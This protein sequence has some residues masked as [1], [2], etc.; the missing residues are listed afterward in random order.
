M[1]TRIDTQPSEQTEK[2]TSN[3]KTSSKDAEKL[4]TRPDMRSK[5][6]E[7]R[8]S[9][10][11]KVPRSNSSPNLVGDGDDK[12]RRKKERRRNRSPV[13]PGSSKEETKRGQRRPVS[14]SLTSN[15]SSSDLRLESR[16]RRLGDKPAKREENIEGLFVLKPKRS[17]SLMGLF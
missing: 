5:D 14:S 17:S 2:M 6:D 12:A 4:K 11:G 1:R 9:A 15:G 7:Q 3:Y 16:P 10:R 13:P 8:L